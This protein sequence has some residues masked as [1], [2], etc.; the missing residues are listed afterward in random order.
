MTDTHNRPCA[1]S[2]LTSYR[3]KG[4]YG[5][6]LIG[7]TDHQDAMRE[8]ARS[9]SD[10]CAAA[11]EVWDAELGRYVRAFPEEH[12]LQNTSPEE[13]RLALYAKHGKGRP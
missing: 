9:T 11:L 1:I 12:H 6:I 4:R 8:A 5:W 10:P 2:G 13:T 3:L 7:A